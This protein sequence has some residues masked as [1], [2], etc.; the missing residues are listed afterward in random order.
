[1]EKEKEMT[2]RNFNPKYFLN[3]LFSFYLLST[4]FIVFESEILQRVYSYGFWFVFGCFT[5][6]HWTNYFLKISR[7]QQIKKQLPLN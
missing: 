1:M 5:G 2:Y 3:W 7:D 4:P 6:I